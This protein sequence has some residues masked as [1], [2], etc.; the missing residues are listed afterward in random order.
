MA[1]DVIQGVLQVWFVVDRTCGATL[2][3][4][5]HGGSD[6]IGREFCGEWGDSGGAASG[7]TR[8]AVCRRRK[9]GGE[10]LG[11]PAFEELTNLMAMDVG[12]D[13]KNDMDVVGLSGG[14]AVEP[15]A[16]LA[17][18]G[19]LRFDQATLGRC[20]IDGRRGEAGS[21]GVL[22]GWVGGFEGLADLVTTAID[23]GQVA[24]VET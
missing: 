24:A 16:T 18:K 22:P 12:W 10:E 15:V 6:A 14:D 21:L 20:E 19:E 2:C 17:E 9:F 23:G 3:P 8:L 1:S 13:I 11:E 4:P 7:T 5:T